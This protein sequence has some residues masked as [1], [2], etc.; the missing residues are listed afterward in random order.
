M[1][2]QSD[3]YNQSLLSTAVVLPLSS[4]TDLARH[5]GHVVVAASASWPPQRPD[6]R[7]TR[8]STSQS[9]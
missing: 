2:I 7:R 5:P 9:R 4:N 3:R 6:C 8:S 1:I